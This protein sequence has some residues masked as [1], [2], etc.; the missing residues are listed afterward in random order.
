[1]CTSLSLSLESSPLFCV[2][3]SVCTLCLEKQRV[4]RFFS[5]AIAREREKIREKRYFGQLMLNPI[6]QSRSE[7]ALSS[8]FFIPHRA[9]HFS[10]IFK[11]FFLCLFLLGKT[12]RE[13]TK[14]EFERSVIKICCCV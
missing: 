8:L 3:Q 10:H 11:T 2:K 9:P 6:T 14:R 12:R 7:F 1:M 13:G 4:R 5:E